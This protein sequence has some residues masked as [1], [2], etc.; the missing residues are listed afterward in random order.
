[1]T[2][3]ILYLTLLTSPSWALALPAEAREEDPVLVTIPSL[4][5]IFVENLAS[6]F[7][8]PD[9]T[10]LDKGYIDLPEAIRVRVSSNTPWRLLVYTDDRN[11][12]AN[13]TQSKPLS[14]ILV[15]TRGCH[16]HRYTLSR[17][18]QEIASSS[19]YAFQEPIL[20][21][22]RMVLDWLTDDPGDYQ[23][24]LKFELESME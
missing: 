3:W 16:G 13:E 10:D 19:H 15:S 2:K 11:L 1:M 12:R 14:H 4:Q 17:Q 21:D 23:V 22:L 20:I 18:A 6:N 8:E 9:A 7:P 5:E 24:A